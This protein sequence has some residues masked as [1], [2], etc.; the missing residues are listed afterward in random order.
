MEQAEGEALEER[1][2]VAVPTG[3]PSGKGRHLS[4]GGPGSVLA[5]ALLGGGGPGSVGPGLGLG[6]PAPPVPSPAV[7]TPNPMIPPSPLGPPFSLLFSS[8]LR[9]Q[10][11]ATCSRGAAGQRP[12]AVDGAELGGRLRRARLR[13]PAGIRRR[14]QRQQPLPRPAPPHAQPR[15]R[16]PSTGFLCPLYSWGL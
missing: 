1:A 3:T 10:L 16:Q 4:G 15:A 5:E 13:P 11:R 9:T 6:S 14:P 12:A 2:P 8:Q 7:A